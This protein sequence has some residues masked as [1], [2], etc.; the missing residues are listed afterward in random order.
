MLVLQNVSQTDSDDSP[1]K[2]EYVV[3]LKKKK[4]RLQ[5]IEYN[6]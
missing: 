3:L 4:K 2:L 6:I 5:F 1:H